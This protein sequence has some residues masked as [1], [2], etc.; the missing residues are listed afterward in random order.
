MRHCR[1]DVVPIS[2]IRA[3]YKPDPI[4]RQKNDVA[5]AVATKYH[6]FVARTTLPLLLGGFG[7]VFGQSRPTRL[8]DRESLSRP[9]TFGDAQVIAFDHV[10]RTTELVQLAVLTT[11]GCN[12]EHQQ[13]SAVPFNAF[14][15]REERWSELQITH[16]AMASSGPQVRPNIFSH[17]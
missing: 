12:G 11:A 14:Q 13:C 15:H 3:A 16:K 6:P 2:I 17:N 9:C 4:A 8:G 7:T 10:S 1:V 5:L